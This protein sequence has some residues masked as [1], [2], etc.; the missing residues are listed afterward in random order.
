MNLII[1]QFRFSSF[2]KTRVLYE[3]MGVDVCQYS[4]VRVCLLCACKGKNISERQN[5]IYCEREIYSM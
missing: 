5:E 2:G 4:S 3:A 1:N